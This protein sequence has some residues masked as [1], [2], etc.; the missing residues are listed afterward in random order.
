MHIIKQ[1]S[2]IILITIILSS[3]SKSIDEKYPLMNLEENIKENPN[4]E[5]KRMEINFSCGDDNLFILWIYW[6]FVKT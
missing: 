4:S 2:K 1:F 3:C 5:K 6:L